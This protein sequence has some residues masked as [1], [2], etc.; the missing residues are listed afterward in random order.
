[1]QP[2]ANVR[3]RGTQ[4]LVATAHLGWE[5]DITRGSTKWPRWADS[6]RSGC[7]IRISVARLC[8]FLI[9]AI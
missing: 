4:A 6:G 2:I 7:G 8:G 5:A 1:M 3:Y 9:P